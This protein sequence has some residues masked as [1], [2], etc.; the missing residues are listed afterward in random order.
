MF[1]FRAYGEAEQL[2]KKW[3]IKFTLTQKKAHI[4]FRIL[5]CLIEF[6]LNSVHS[7]YVYNS[8]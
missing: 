3:T 8:T 6:L 5:N 4:S 7:I 2:A 1:N